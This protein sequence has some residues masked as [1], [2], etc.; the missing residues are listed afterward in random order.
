VTF[1]SLNF[2]L[3]PIQV[4]NRSSWRRSVWRVTDRQT[5]RPRFLCVRSTGD[6]LASIVV[7]Y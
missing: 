2:D 3:R 6:E 1:P 4:V 5:D 7:Y